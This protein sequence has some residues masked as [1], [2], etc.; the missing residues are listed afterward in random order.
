MWKLH[1]WNHRVDDYAEVPDAVYNLEPP[2]SGSHG[3]ADPKI[4]R[5]F[6]DALR[7]HYDVW[8]TPQAARNS[9]AAGCRGAD[10]IR[11]NGMPLDVP[12]LPEH[13]ADYDFIRCKRKG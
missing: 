4:V 9:V 2:K 5:S 6:V 13:L 12:P 10:S 11:S 1:L 3:G 7:G 8:S